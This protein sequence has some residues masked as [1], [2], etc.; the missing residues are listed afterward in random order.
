MKL[1]DLYRIRDFVPDFDAI[2]AEFVERSRAFSA[3]A[4]VLADV[5]YG[6][7]PREILDV[8]L[9]E[10]QKTGAPLH[11]FV[12]GGYW[13]SGE[14]ENYHF[15]AAPVL[16]TGAVAAIVE[17][18][19]MPG[20][21]LGVLVDQVRRAVLW[22]ER[23]AGD[24]GADPRR[25]TVSGHSAGAHLASF[26]AAIGPQ[27]TAATLLPSP[28]GL[29]LLSG[30]Y[31][32][33]DIPHSFLRNE[34]E[35]TVAEATAWSPL[36]STQLPCPMRII[37][38]GGEETRPFNEQASAFDMRLNVQGCASELLPI[39]GLNHM[40][41]VLDL[42]DPDGQLGSRLAMMVASS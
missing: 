11:V 41:V 4:S 34:A 2:A 16:A 3:N 1:E 24:F 9:P 17:Y 8:I 7:R 5:R 18:D 12:H 27:E 26:L 23:H 33:S 35:M 28:R 21:R 38:F 19:L 6:T 37:A 25:L 15:V 30:I 31:D 20:E 36:T 42:A 32:L 22:L 40:N 14:K 29:L 39:P 10:N 13:R